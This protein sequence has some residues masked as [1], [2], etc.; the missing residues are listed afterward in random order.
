M[1]DLVPKNGFMAST[2]RLRS[3]R[4]Q[5]RPVGYSRATAEAAA[6]VAVGTVMGMAIRQLVGVV[7]TERVEPVRV[8]VAGLGQRG[9]GH[10][11]G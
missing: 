8:K 2:K 9:L 1:T 10:E 3:S 5:G 7:N 4:G 11:V 6:G